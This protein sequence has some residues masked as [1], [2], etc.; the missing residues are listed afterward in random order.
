MPP[1]VRRWPSITDKLEEAVRTV[2]I[3]GFMSLMYCM[4][5]QREEVMLAMLHTMCT[6]G[7]LRCPWRGCDA[8][9][10][11]ARA[12]TFHLQIHDVGAGAYTCV[13]CGSA[14]KSARELMQ[15]ACAQ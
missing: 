5:R 6:D 12:L 1:Q 2:S 9:L 3:P 14:F 15:H 13:R 7:L 8:L 11:S 10:G 4:H